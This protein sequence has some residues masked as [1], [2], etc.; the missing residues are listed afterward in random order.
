MQDKRFRQIRLSFDLVMKFYNTIIFSTSDTIL[1]QRLLR[2]QQNQYLAVFQQRRFCDDVFSTLADEFGDFGAV[3]GTALNE[4]NQAIGY[5]KHGGKSA[6]PR[7]FCYF[8][9]SFFWKTKEMKSWLVFTTSIS[10][11]L[12]FIIRF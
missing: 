8:D 3:F 11:I 7:S 6:C 10:W 2:I 1:S 9:D 12:G 5:K 4:R